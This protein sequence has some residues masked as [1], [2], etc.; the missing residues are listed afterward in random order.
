MTTTITMI[1]A[2]RMIIAHYKADEPL[3][4]IG[5]PGMGKTALFEDVCYNS[6]KVGYTDFRFPQRDVADIA[7]MRVPDAKTGY[8]KHY[9]P[10][11]MP[12]DAKKHGPK[13]ILVCE[14]INA[15]GPMLQAV[16]YGIINERRCGTHK[17]LPG[18]VPMG[19][20]NHHTH[21]AAAQRI[22]TA[23]ANRFCV[24]YVEPDLEAWMKQYGSEHVDTR[25]LAF[26]RFR[27]ELFSLMPGETATNKQGTTTVK[28]SKDAIEFPSAR[29]WTKAF[30]F[31]DSHDRFQHF[32]GYV[33]EDVAREF[34][35][36]WRIMSQAISIDE[37]EANP[38][39]AR[40]P[41]ETDPGTYYAV[42]AMIARMMDRKNIGKL[43]IYI[44][45]L[46]A[47]YQVAI[48]QDATKR[49]PDLMQTSQYGAF[50]VRNQ[51][52]LA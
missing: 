46:I 7:G 36:F 6:L 23:L 8:M 21:G 9:L 40:L 34:E 51:E 43:A 49:K 48:F 14:E 27:P 18:W 16:G 32:S 15:V 17:L 24:K 30:K 10:D 2:R 41:S 33:G 39:T 44:E 29:S 37:I 1:E 42:C 47:D 26:L 25:G 50:A 38:K 35:A 52:L 11:E 28:L 3:L 13:G 19:A 22:T 20:G 4:L 45:R 5:R 12:V 31:I